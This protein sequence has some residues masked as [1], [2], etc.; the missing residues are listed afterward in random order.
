MP[1]PQEAAMARSD[2][3]APETPH[4]G[5]TPALG[6]WS[7]LRLFFARSWQTLREV[8]TVLHPCRFSV[9]MV[10]AGGALLFASPQGRELAVG[11]P[12]AP[13]LAQVAFHFAVF[14]WAFE[15][16]YW[17]RLMLDVTNGLDRQRNALGMRFGPHE[18]WTI[19]NGPRVIA[20][21]AY[22]VAAIAVG[23]A[24]AWIQFALLAAAGTLFYW[25]L[26]K[27]VAI[28]DRLHA[29]LGRPFKTLSGEP[30]VIASLRDLPPF[31][32]AVL[33]GSIALSVIATVRVVQDPVAFGWALGAAAVPF[34]GFALIVPIGSLL[35][36]WFRL[37]GA[38]SG[39]AG[40]RGYPV[41]TMLALWALLVGAI[42]D[43]HAVRTVP[44]PAGAAD[45]AARP[46]VPEAALRWHAAASKASGHERPPL[47]VIAT[48]G[49]GLR[50]AYWTATLLG[51]LQDEAPGFGAHVFAISGVSGGS[52]GAAVFATLLADGTAGLPAGACAQGPR[53]RK[54]YECAGQ[55]VL[56]RDFLAP[57][58]ASLVFPDLMQ[59]FVPY[60]V[61]PDRAAAL[62]QSWER[63]WERAGLAPDTWTR[64]T[65]TQLWPRD[66]PW[67]PALLLNGTHVE[68]GKRI[69]TSSVR[70]DGA[71][72]PDAYDFFALA[73]GDLRLSTAALNSARFPYV[74]PA[75][76]L[77]RG[78]DNLGHIVDGG[79]FENFGAVTAL[80]A[81][82][83]ALRAIGEAGKWAEP[84]LIQISND[85]ALGPDELDVDRA[86]GPLDR[87]GH[88][89]ANETLS[90]PRTL[91]KT[92]DARGVLAYKEFLGNVPATRR[93]HFRLCA[94]R[95]E[96]EPALGWVLAQPSL[97]QMHRIARDD[98][99]GNRAEF[100]R[101]V[102]AIRAAP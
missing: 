69:I 84:F 48:A 26:V 92:R 29:V 51:A 24:G 67:V 42:V 63:A 58:A 89:I 17:S 94:I 32:Q 23:L 77:V 9:F 91:L 6:P 43:N 54:A 15:S 102:A 41:V 101:V 39:A 81:M 27:R 46:S 14:L 22:V 25:L 11:L 93:A 85:P 34:L 96:V 55:A 68:S 61:F 56:A 16:W 28:T 74:S 53:A 70:V 1:A 45:P 8:A 80:Q 76:T 12:G 87:A 7:R 98:A 82:R 35:V 72:F 60:P 47:I 66:G 100:D 88:R 3:V 44:A 71:A 65:F 49:G 4:P 13:L 10:L 20:A 95:G 50:A 57:T 73:S 19:R 99:C 59:R 97:D 33:W 18:A 90:P 5:S 40:A 86:A 62:E 83:A 52:V 79:Y 21:A 30:R 75:G 78:G 38:Q 37:G 31:S 64:R 2:S 36:Y